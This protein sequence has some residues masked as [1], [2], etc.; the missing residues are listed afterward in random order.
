MVE[1]DTTDSL[2]LRTSTP[3]ERRIG[4]GI[5]LLVRNVGRHENEIAGLR[6]R[7]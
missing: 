4:E 1:V 7:R 3:L 2:S 6:L 5:D